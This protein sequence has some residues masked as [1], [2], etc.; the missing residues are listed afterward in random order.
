MCFKLP[1]PAQG[2]KRVTPFFSPPASLK[3]SHLVAS[4]QRRA[5]MRSA[6][7][8]RAGK[9]KGG[10][11]ARVMTRARASCGGCDTNASHSSITE[12]W[13]RMRERC[14]GGRGRVRCKPVFYPPSD[15]DPVVKKS[16]RV[17]PYHKISIWKHN[18]RFF[19]PITH[20]ITQTLT[21]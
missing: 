16:E 12:G 11:S 4:T 21:R 13:C 5:P 6:A 2:A 14:R 15:F 3:T 19:F 1:L 17:G 10:R 7:L 8:S 9:I 18:M 20:S